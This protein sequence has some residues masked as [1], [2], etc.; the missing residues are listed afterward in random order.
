MKCLE[1]LKARLSAVKDKF[2]LLETIDQKNIYLEL[3]RND[4]DFVKVEEFLQCIKYADLE[5][6]VKQLI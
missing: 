2:N 4:T 5:S 6:K 3:F 1:E